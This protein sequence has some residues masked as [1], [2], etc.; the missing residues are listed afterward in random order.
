[1]GQ[2]TKCGLGKV[3]HQ[4]VGLIRLID[5]GDVLDQLGTT[6]EAADQSRRDDGLVQAL[7]KISTIRHTRE[8]AS[9]R[10]A[11]TPF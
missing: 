5:V 10:P 6:V 11:I 3:I 8:H 1:V 7:V 9:P 4:D 2:A